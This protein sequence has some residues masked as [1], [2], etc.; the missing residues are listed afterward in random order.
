MRDFWSIGPT[1]AVQA[2]RAYGFSAQQAERLVVL[3]LRHDRGSFREL[4]TSQKR[5]LF[6]RWLV[7][8]G[9]LNEGQPFMAAAPVRETRTSRRSTQ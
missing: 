1:A 6:A 7:A 9:H 3:K 2:L 4:T 5:L 8:H